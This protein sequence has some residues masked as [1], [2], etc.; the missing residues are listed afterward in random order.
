MEVE[1]TPSPF[2]HGAVYSSSVPTQ[3][4][5]DMA[6]PAH[7]DP[8][9]RKQTQ[10]M[11]GVNFTQ[12]SPISIPQLQKSAAWNLHGYAASAPSNMDPAW[13]RKPDFAAG[14]GGANILRYTTG[15]FEMSLKGVPPR[16]ACALASSLLLPPT[17]LHPP[18]TEEHVLRAENAAKC[19][20]W[21]TG[22][23]GAPSANGRKLALDSSTER[24]SW[25]RKTTVIT[26]TSWMFPLFR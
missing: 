6:R 11:K 18:C 3:S 20:G 21:R 16:S 9:Y 12:A 19:M 17:R 25:L 1:S 14:G 10:Q 15:V 5:W 22:T 24:P 2:M 7:E 4:H 23:C 8:E 26:T 13:G